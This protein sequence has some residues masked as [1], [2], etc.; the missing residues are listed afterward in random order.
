VCLPNGRLATVWIGCSGVGAERCG[1][2]PLTGAD[3]SRRESGQ[4]RGWLSAEPLESNRTFT[5][6][7]LVLQLQ[8]ERWL[9]V[10]G[11]SARGGR[12]D[13]VAEQSPSTWRIPS[14]RRLTRPVGRFSNRRIRRDLPA[15]RDIGPPR[16]TACGSLTPAGAPSML[17]LCR[18]GA[19]AGLPA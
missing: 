7:S 6:F 4:L 18:S 5:V 17:R 19:E 15:S 9:L 3:A 2:P 14:F 13:R 11:V 16:P 10:P 8:N 1:A 12:S